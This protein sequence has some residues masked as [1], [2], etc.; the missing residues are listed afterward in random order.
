M[1]K[2]APTT[3][4]SPR[5]RAAGRTGVPNSP[6]QG[7]GPACLSA[8]FLPNALFRV[9]CPSATAARAS[10]LR[11]CPSAQRA[12]PGGWG[13]AACPQHPPTPVAQRVPPSPASP[14]TVTQ[15]GDPRF[16]PHPRDGG[17][18][19]LVGPP[20]LSAHPFPV[21]RCPQHPMVMLV[22]TLHPLPGHG[23]AETV[24][25]AVQPEVHLAGESLCPS[26]AGHPNTYSSLADSC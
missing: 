4:N 20:F 3:T 21:C 24:S 14:V 16:S 11:S 25:S 2:A 26:Q 7:R 18:P 9:C 12:Q 5:P 8:L 23:A 1:E 17:A 19:S 15:P 13:A 22:P 10:C 6:F